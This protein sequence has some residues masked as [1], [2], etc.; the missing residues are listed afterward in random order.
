MNEMNLKAGDLVSIVRDTNNSLAIIPNSLRSSESTNEATALIMQSECGNSLKRKVIS[1][2]LAGYNIMH[3][4]A[5]SG[6]ISPL[7][8]DAIR[9]VIRRNLVGTE[10]IA[11]SS[12]II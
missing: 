2:Y 1:M 7:Q 6:R 3:L 10:I 11:D 9:E 12:E 4:R 5:K 8:R